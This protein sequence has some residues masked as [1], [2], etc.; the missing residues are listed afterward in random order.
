[1]TEKD[2]NDAY[3]FLRENNHSIPDNV[4]DFMKS[5]SLSRF[6]ELS[7]TVNCNDCENHGV[8]TF[9]SRCSRNPEYCDFFEEDFN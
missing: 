7:N 6:L 3:V 1:M 9:C 8:Q 5:A 2:I 4:L